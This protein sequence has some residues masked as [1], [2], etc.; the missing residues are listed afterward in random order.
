[1]CETSETLIVLSEYNTVRRIEASRDVLAADEMVGC[2]CQDEI[3]KNRCSVI[4]SLS[5]NT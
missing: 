2:F 5:S 3:M 1:M 4:L